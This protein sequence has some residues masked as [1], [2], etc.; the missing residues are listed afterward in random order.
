MTGRRL[1]PLLILAATAQVH[2]LVPVGTTS[3]GAVYWHGHRIDP[4]YT[5]SVGFRLDPDT[6]WTGLYI[7]GLPFDLPSRPVPGADSIRKAHGW[8]D[9]VRQ[10]EVSKSAFARAHEIKT[11]DPSVS[12][13]AV[14]AAEFRKADDVVDSA[15]VTPSSDILLYWR[16]EPRP[17]PIHFGS[18]SPPTPSPV[19][20]AMQRAQA[21]GELSL[22]SQGRS[23]LIFNG[24]VS[25]PAGK[26]P[27]VL[28][29][30]DSLRAGLPVVNPVIGRHNLEVLRSP[31]PMDSLRAREHPR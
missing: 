25:L 22:L 29:Q 12:Y 7:N 23:L 4:P 24:V 28:A 26:L 15:V 27:E 8:P 2:G 30:V 21:V 5:M 9:P 14:L 3:N 16:N 19:I 1:L 20:G 18:V 11:Q 17:M 10:S 31:E 13:V 6:T